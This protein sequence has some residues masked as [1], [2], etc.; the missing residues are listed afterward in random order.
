[1]Y[2]QLLRAILASRSRSAVSQ[3]V[4]RRVNI[5]AALIGAAVVLSLEAF[6]VR[7]L[8][9]PRL[10]IRVRGAAARLCTDE[11]C[12]TARDSEP[13]FRSVNRGGMR[14]PGRS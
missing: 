11:V 1:M 8:D 3:V 4:R 6:G 2:P 7:D 12:G 9:P 14:T 5:E 13:A 10:A